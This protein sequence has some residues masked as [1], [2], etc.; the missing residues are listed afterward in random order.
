MK[1]PAYRTSKECEIFINM[2]RKY[3][4]E[5]TGSFDMPELISRLAELNRSEFIRCDNC[6]GAIQK[7]SG[8]RIGV[9]GLTY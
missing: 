8:S 1:L 6:L 7:V 2:M 5:T 9:I 4:S 3:W